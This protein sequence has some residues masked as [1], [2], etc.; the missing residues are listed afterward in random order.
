MAFVSIQPKRSAPRSA[1]PGSSLSSSTVSTA[2][3]AA[4]PFSP[5]QLLLELKSVLANRPAKE[6]FAHQAQGVSDKGAE[7]QEEHD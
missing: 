6:Y 4:S 5:F 2:P 1:A 3:V 7:M